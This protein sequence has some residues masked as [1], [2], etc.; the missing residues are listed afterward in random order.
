[1]IYRVIMNLLIELEHLT[2]CLIKPAILFLII[3]LNF[4]LLKG[5]EIS[6][7]CY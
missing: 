2:Q 7:G 4:L 6:Y 3:E 1:M 5:I